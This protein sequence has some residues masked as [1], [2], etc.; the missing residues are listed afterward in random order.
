MKIE[1][2]RMA[3]KLLDALREVWSYNLG[4]I[5]LVLFVAIVVISIAAVVSMPPDFPSKWEDPKSWELNPRLAPP[6]WV[7]ILGY[8]LSPTEKIVFTKP[9]RIVKKGD[10]EYIVY[11]AKYNLDVNDY[12]QDVIVAFVEPRTDLKAY[13]NTSTEFI[14]NITRPDGKEITVAEQSLTIPQLSNVR[15]RFSTSIAIQSATEVLKLE[16]ISIPLEKANQVVFGIVKVFS[17]GSY[18]LQPLKGTYTIKLCVKVYNSELLE[19]Y[20]SVS[21]R[22]KLLLEDVRKLEQ[23]VANQVIIYVKGNRYGLLGTDIDGRDLALGVFYGFPV[24]LLVGFFAAVTATFIGAI[25]GVVSG[26]YGGLIDDL[27]QRIVDVLSNIPLLPIL[28]LVG[29]I[30]QQIFTNPWHRLLTIIAFLILFSWGGVAIMVRSMT[31]S[32]KAEPYVEAA[33]AAGAGDLRIIFRHVFPQIV[34]Y[35]FAVLVFNVPGA[36]LTE[37]GLSVLGIRHGLPTWGDILSRANEHR[38]IAFGCW[39]WIIP[40]GVMLALTSFTFVSLGMALETMVEPRL[41]GR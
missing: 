3:R 39:W 8:Q 28:V 17:N 11:E 38:E 5:G 20:A 32:I 7:T 10:Y 22:A 19:K 24:A 30:V 31:L 16:N 34:P 27:I 29:V 40:P 26:Y 15:I 33:K 14:L 9:T 21:E 12:P 1:T 36:I 25:A 41:R 35:L 6:D 37:A 4:K 23:G 13:A 2:R 18:A